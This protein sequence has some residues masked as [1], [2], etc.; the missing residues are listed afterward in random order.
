LPFSFL[1]RFFP[2]RSS[3]AVE[4]EDNSTKRKNEIMW[5]IFR[6]HHQRSR[7]LYEMY[8]VKNKITREVYEFALKYGFGDAN[9]IAK[10]KKV[11]FI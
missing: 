4:S 3:F 7:Y 1:F 10:W 9:L 2:S 6:L 8:Y 11:I 5:P